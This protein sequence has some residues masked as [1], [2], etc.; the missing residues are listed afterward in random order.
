MKKRVAVL[1]GD[2]IGKEVTDA[3]M[4]VVDEIGRRF[5]HEFEW[6]HGAIGGEAIDSVGNP[7]PEDTIKICEESDAILLGAVGGPKVGKPTFASPA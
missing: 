1:R 2:G 5:Q 4:A 7:L 6:V 3:A